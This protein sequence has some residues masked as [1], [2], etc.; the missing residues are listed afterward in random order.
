MIIYVYS[1]HQVRAKGYFLPDTIVDL[2]AY[3]GRKYLRKHYGGVDPMHLKPM[4]GLTKHGAALAELPCHVL[5]A[6]SDDYISVAQGREIAEAYPGQCSFSTI[7]GGHF[8]ARP[9]QAVLSLRHRIMGRLSIHDDEF[10]PTSA[11]IGGGVEVKGGDEGG[12]GGAAI[13][14]D[15]CSDKRAEEREAKTSAEKKEGLL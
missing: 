13:G 5:A 10:C 3:V 4:E 1:L 11:P 8:G 9:R 6:E 2:S 14:C 12:I 15:A 7:Q